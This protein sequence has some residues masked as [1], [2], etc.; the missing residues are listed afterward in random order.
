MGNHRWNRS[1]LGIASILVALNTVTV[2]TYK[3]P[4]ALT[5]TPR[6]QRRPVRIALPQKQSIA[7]PSLRK[8]QVWIVIAAYNESSR[9]TATLRGLH[10][11]GYTN[12]VVVDDGS[13]DDTAREAARSDITVLRHPINCGQGAALQTGIDFAISRDAEIV[14][15]F[16]ADNQHDAKEIDRLVRPVQEGRV[17]VVLGSRFA[18]KTVAMPT[19]RRLILLGATW[20]TRLTTRLSVSDAHNGFRAF[21]RRAMQ[22]I[23]IRQPR[24]AHASEILEEIARHELSW[25]EAPVTIHYSTDTLAKG[26]S[27]WDAIRIMGQLFLGRF[28]R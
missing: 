26:Q 1:H 27:S 16:D 10:E 2:K 28:V 9:I 4:I 11:A 7:A 8:T 24:M 14:V 17:D 13:K 20:Y 3:P 6:A 23:R 19:S 15:T 22:T 25:Q 18:G 12:I 21:S 5:G